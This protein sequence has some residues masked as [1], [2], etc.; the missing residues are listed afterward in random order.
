MALTLLAADESALLGE[1]QRVDPHRYP[2]TN[3]TDNLGV[4]LSGGSIIP[5]GIFQADCLS[6][7]ERPGREERGRARLL[8]VPACK[9]GRNE[10]GC[11]TTLNI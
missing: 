2:S 6:W 9:P 8:V 11:K 4:G 3:P 10:M 5:L 7:I 1:P